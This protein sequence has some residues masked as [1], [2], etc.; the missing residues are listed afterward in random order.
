MH[1]FAMCSLLVLGFAPG[2]LGAPTDS[3]EVGIAW[4]YPGLAVFSFIW[5]FADAYA[6]GANDVV[7]PCVHYLSKGAI[8]AI[9]KSN[10][11]CAQFATEFCLGVVQ[12]WRGSWAWFSVDWVWFIFGACR[13]CPR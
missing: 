11:C 4:L 5:A 6:I 9:V 12:L 8:S 7:G 10:V 1:W 3:S 2:A 13:P